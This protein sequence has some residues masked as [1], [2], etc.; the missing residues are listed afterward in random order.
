MDWMDRLDR[1]ENHVQKRIKQGW[2]ML[3]P[4]YKDSA[5]MSFNGDHYAVEIDYDGNIT[6]RKKRAKRQ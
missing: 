1:F 4:Y 3:D 6:E 5:E 2:V